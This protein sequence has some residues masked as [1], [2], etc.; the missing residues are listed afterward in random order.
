[1]ILRDSQPASHVK[2]DT[3]P[4]YWATDVLVIDADAPGVT[5]GSGSVFGGDVVL[6]YIAGRT[7][8][9]AAEKLAELL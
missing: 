3:N 8:V 5:A 9:S 7:T 1:M 4:D 6:T 2:F